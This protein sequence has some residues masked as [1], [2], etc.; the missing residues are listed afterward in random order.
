MSIEEDRIKTEEEDEKDAAEAADRARLEAERQARD[1]EAARVNAEEE[2]RRQ[3]EQRV[4]EE[5]AKLEAIKE[6]E[7]EKARAEAEQQARIQAMTQQ[8]A[9][10]RQLVQLKQ[11][12]GKKRMRIALIV[13][14][15]VVVLGGTGAGFYINHQS[16]L[17][18]KLLADQE[19]ETRRIAEAAKQEKR[20]A[21]KKEKERTEQIAKLLKQID[22]AADPAELKR[23]KDELAS[24]QKGGRGGTRRG[25]AS[26]SS[27]GPKPT[28]KECKTGDPLC[29][30]DM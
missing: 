4:R 8:Q 2:R 3:D 12:K 20:K 10:E 13:G 19:A 5:A 30:G 7:V 25:G 15:C 16:E 17:D 1:Q 14:A 29:A 26:G 18:A 6:A 24:A 23:L 21:A 27:G 9:H 28:A 22:A 11:D